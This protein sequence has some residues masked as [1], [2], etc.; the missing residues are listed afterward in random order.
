[1][2]DSAIATEAD[3]ADEKCTETDSSMD[4][5]KFDARDF[6]FGINIHSREFS[7]GIIFAFIRL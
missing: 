7:L 5:E 6:I 1:M 2:W 3:Q 4:E